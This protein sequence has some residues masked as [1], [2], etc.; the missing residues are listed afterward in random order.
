MDVS[1]IAALLLMMQPGVAGMCVPARA[2][3]D[4]ASRAEPDPMGRIA[5]GQTSQ[6]DATCT[7]AGRPMLDANGGRT[8]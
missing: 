4:G 2:G 3:I 1:L 6:K 5:S 7:P 8:Y